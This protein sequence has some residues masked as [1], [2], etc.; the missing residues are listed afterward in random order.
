[1]P[2]IAVAM[3]LRIVQAQI[4]SI[5][6]RLEHRPIRQTTQAIAMNEMEQGGSSAQKLAATEFHVA[7][8]G[9]RPDC[10]GDQPR[11]AD[12]NFF[13]E[14]SLKEFARIQSLSLPQLHVN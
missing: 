13:H 3:S 12:S 8:D 1:M 6:Q 7:T 2:V 10:P 4:V 11:E 9:I 14:V 5:G